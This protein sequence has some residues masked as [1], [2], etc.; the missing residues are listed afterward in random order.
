MGSNDM[1]T[2]LTFKEL[3]HQGW[4]ERAHSYDDY[5]SRITSYGVVPLLEAAEIAPRQKVLDVCCGTGLFA[6][7]AIERGASVTGIDLSAEM[8]AVAERKGLRGYFR[9]GDAEALPFPDESFDRVVCNFGLYHLPAPDRAITEAAR[10]LRAGGHYAFTTWCG[11]DISPFFRIISEAVQ[12][13]GTM[14]VGLPSGPPPF[15]LADRVETGRIM[16]EAGFAKLSFG[17]LQAVLQ[18]SLEHIIDFLEQGTV[19]VT[20]VLRAQH[21]DARYRIE[22]RIREGFKEYAQ[23][24][25]V[26]MILP[27]LV[28]SGSKV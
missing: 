1:T 18:W 28:V 3:E 27:A 22:Q 15:R 25:M 16:N 24:G 11:P 23:N 6:A 26:H 17:E 10:V 12:S 21:R 9:T 14:D 8:I 13:Q 5:T 20:M 19:R 2:Q 4:D 7:A